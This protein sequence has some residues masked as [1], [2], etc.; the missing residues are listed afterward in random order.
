MPIL[1]FV[2]YQCI[3]G[4][5][6]RKH[7]KLHVGN[8]GTTEAYIIALVSYALETPVGEILLNNVKL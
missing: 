7:N 4:D 5:W 6:S 8:A 3:S 2:L 1:M